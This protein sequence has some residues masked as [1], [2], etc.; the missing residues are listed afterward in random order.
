ME[1]SP[2][3]I[4]SISYWPTVCH[5][6]NCMSLRQLCHY[7]KCKMLLCGSNEP[8]QVCSDLCTYCLGSIIMIYY[9][10]KL[11]SIKL[12][13][14]LH[15]IIKQ[16]VSVCN[17]VITMCNVINYIRMREKYSHDLYTM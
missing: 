14:P 16:S 13:E 6:V 9:I 4:I 3:S 5:Y 12:T 1:P 7:V 10:D 2:E 8:V 17:D 15:N 11:I